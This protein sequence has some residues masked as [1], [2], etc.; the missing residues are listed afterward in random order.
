MYTWVRKKKRAWSCVLVVA[1]IAGS[2]RC[3]EQRHREEDH[4]VVQ[5]KHNPSIFHVTD[6]STEIEK[7]YPSCEQPI[8]ITDWESLLIENDTYALVIELGGHVHSKDLSVDVD[9]DASRIDVIATIDRHSCLENHWYV[10]SNPELHQSHIN[11]YELVMSFQ[12]GTLTLS[13]PRRR[14]H[15]VFEEDEEVSKQQSGD[16]ASRYTFLKDQ[17][18]SLQ[19]YK[20]F[21]LSSFKG[22]I[23]PISTSTNSDEETRRTMINTNTTTTETVEEANTKEESLR[24]SSKPL[25]IQTSK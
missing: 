23:R 2:C 24:K 15:Q 11:L 25:F 12:D 1:L 13:A 6:F 10:D 17:L 8:Q 3:Q 4:D 5:S 7:R 19:F 21:S 20:L 22:L 14:S 18:T 16:G 9:Y